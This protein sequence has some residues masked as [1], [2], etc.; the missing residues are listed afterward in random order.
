M[1]RWLGLITFVIAALIF[2][3]CM[4]IP[5]PSPITGSQTP[6]APLTEVFSHEDFVTSSTEAQPTAATPA[7]SK[8]VETREISKPR[9]RQSCENTTPRT[10]EHSPTPS[11]KPPEPEKSPREEKDG[12]PSTTHTSPISPPPRITP[13]TAKRQKPLAPKQRAAV[14]RLTN[15]LRPTPTQPKVFST[16]TKATT[17]K[18]PFNDAAESLAQLLKE[19]VAMQHALP[20]KTESAP[21]TETDQILENLKQLFGSPESTHSSEYLVS[22]TASN[23]LTTT[24]PATTPPQSHSP[25]TTDND[26]LAALVNAPQPDSMAAWKYR[27]QQLRSLAN[28]SN[29]DKASAIF[30]IEPQDPTIFKRIALQYRMDVLLATPSK[31]V[32]TIVPYDKGFIDKAQYFD[33]GAYLKQQYGLS[34]QGLGFPWLNTLRERH[35]ATQ[36]TPTASVEISLLIPKL[37]AEAIMGKIVLGCHALGY[38]LDEV[39]ACY[40]TFV[41]R[42][43]TDKTIFDYEVTR[44]ILKDATEVRANA[45]EGA[46]NHP[47]T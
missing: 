25:K 43:L 17:T 2:Y 41:G 19:S 15:Q 4:R 37:E 18:D 42:S 24:T 16:S 46:P 20:R 11:P 44:L 14:A 23:Q 36:L 10:A 29:R 38:S 6:T 45:A 12:K 7:P 13:A 27:E 1:R 34:V 5:L 26:Q 3:A 9:K 40:G 21:R 31:N 33:D 39:N 47:P 35:V 28:N 22:S 8:T 30:R 32:Y